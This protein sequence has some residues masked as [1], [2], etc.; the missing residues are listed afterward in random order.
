M[1]K[2]M[3]LLNEV[4]GEKVGPSDSFEAT[5]WSVVLAA[6]NPQS[7]QAQTAL[8]E[9][10]RAYW[11]PLYVFIRRQGTNAE[12]AQDLVQGFFAR[13]IEK[14]FVAAAEPEKGRFRSFLL[15]ALK[16]YMANQWDHANRE[17]RGG[18]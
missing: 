6:G 15:L 1:N 12:D 18:R 7:P 17:K 3:P 9:L 8:A 16:R 13:L 10:C 2:L 14:N 4:G 11:Y 5:H